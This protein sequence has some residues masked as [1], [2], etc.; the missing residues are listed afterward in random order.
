MSWLIWRLLTQQKTDNATPYA[1]DWWRDRIGFCKTRN[2]NINPEFT[3]KLW[4]YFRFVRFIKYRGFTAQS[5]VY[6]QIVTFR[7]LSLTHLAN[8]SFYLSQNNFHVHEKPWLYGGY[9]PVD[10]HLRCICF[11]VKNFDLF[12]VLPRA[13]RAQSSTNAPTTR[14]NKT[15]PKREM[16]PVLVFTQSRDQQS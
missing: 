15:N 4:S 12:L 13:F 7:G 10:I 14:R 2:R 6:R 5:E 11:L 8:C 16:N 9:T 1:N 3:V